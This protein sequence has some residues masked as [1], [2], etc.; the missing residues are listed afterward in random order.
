MALR[1]RGRKT[2]RFGPLRIHLSQSGY[3]GWGL[4]VWRWTY[5]HTTGRQSFDTPGFGSVQWGDRRRGER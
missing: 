4:K 1:F 2:L 5:S 3:T